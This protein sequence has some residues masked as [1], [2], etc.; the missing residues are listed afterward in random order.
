MNSLSIG[1]L[2]LC[3]IELI[4]KDNKLQ[5]RE[6]LNNYFSPSLLEEIDLLRSWLHSLENGKLIYCRGRD[7][8]RNEEGIFESFS[9]WEYG[10]ALKMNR[11]LFFLWEKDV[12]SLLIDGCNFLDQLHFECSETLPIYHSINFFNRTVVVCHGFCYEN[13]P[14]YPFIAAL[15]SALATIGYHVIIPDFRPRY[16]ISMNQ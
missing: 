6:C 3:S 14:N 7:I 8:L 5:F 4:E 1:G 13:G 2:F 15:T 11:R 16:S 10:Y 9:N 12:E